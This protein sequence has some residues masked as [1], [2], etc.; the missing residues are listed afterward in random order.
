MKRTILFLL[1][2]TLFGASR[3]AVGHSMPPKA[4]K[5]PRLVYKVADHRPLHLD[6]YLPDSCKM[7]DVPLLVFIHGGS[8][9]HGN[10]DEICHGFQ[11]QIL[12]RLL[13][14]GYAVASVEYRLVNDEGQPRYPAPLS[15]CK[16]AVKWLKKQAALYRIDTTRVAISGTS[17]GAHLAMMTAYAPDALAPGDTLLAGFSSHV[18][19]CIDIYGP[20]DLKKMF[21]PT[22]NPLAVGLARLIMGK[23]LIRERNI[24]LNAFT[25]RAA[26]HPYKRRAA[27]LKFSPRSYVGHAVPTAI[28]HGNKDRLVPFGQS[29]QLERQLKKH[30]IPCQLHVVEGQDH[31]FPTLTEGAG[32]EISGKVHRFLLLHN[33]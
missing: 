14:G 7:A 28:F 15:D 17:A 33:Q 12:H 10:R 32:A 31:A 2:L 4:V 6:L 22:L 21:H 1:C 3:A 5:V 13:A 30:R 16:D 27:C 24:L 19:C 11:F 9:M 18:N 20:T 8:W 23:E 26:T 25:G 29:K